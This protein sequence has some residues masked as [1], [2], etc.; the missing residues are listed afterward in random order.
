MRTQR[1]RRAIAGAGFIL[2]AAWHRGVLAKVLVASVSLGAGGLLIAQQGP[3]RFLRY[4]E[5]EEVISRYAALPPDDSLV[6]S[7][8]AA[9]AIRGAAE[10][11][12]WVRARDREIRG[13]IARG[14]EDSISNLTLY[15][16]SYTRLPRLESFEQAGTPG[17]ELTRPARARVLALALALRRPEKNERVRFVQD[18][19]ARRGV[20]REHSTA[21][22]EEYLS[23]NL[24]RF[25]SEQREYEKKLEEAGRAGDPGRL[26]FTR[27]TLYAK[28]GL[29][30]DTS[31]LPNLALEGTLR[32]LVN[33]GVLA[34]GSIRRIAVIGPGLD[35]SDKRDGYDFYPLQT[36]QPFAMVEAVVR[37][38][39]GDPADLRVVTFDLN[40]LVNTHARS[41]AER[42]RSGHPY[43]VQLPRDR[44]GDWNREAVSYWEHFGELLGSPVHPLP[45]PPALGRVVTRAVTIRPRVAARVEAVDLDI[46]A[47]T[48]DVLPSAA[49]DLVVATNV[50][51]YY[52]HFEQSLAMASVAHMMN[53]GGVFLV[54]HV[55][56]VQH[57]ASLE[58]LGRRSV[59]YSSSGAYGDDVVV[60]RRW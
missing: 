56:P 28:R 11:D 37:L 49:F 44:E 27:E 23:S 20:P 34:P 54:N 30:I 9:S 58:Y 32:A 8:P 59:S 52:D 19:L 1:H 42:G 39:L 13:R 21:A 4:E 35:F 53:P 55:L 51:V 57:P 60:Y 45:A 50:L 33:K 10:W 36:L 12:P 5:A 24:R 40:P 43:V 46:V 14:V 3:A 7:R 17:G 48:L 16:T 29:S 18:F 2:G 15:G 47:E 31:L 41:L 38:G 26:L 6:G 25:V 22:L